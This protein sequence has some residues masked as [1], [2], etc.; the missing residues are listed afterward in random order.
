MALDTLS[1][2]SPLSP[3]LMKLYDQPHSMRDE[4]LWSL[5]TPL[6]PAIKRPAKRP[7]LLVSDGRFES[8]WA[9][10]A[11]CVREAELFVALMRRCDVVIGIKESGCDHHLWDRVMWRHVSY[12]IASV[13]ADPETIAGILLFLLPFFI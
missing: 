4:A 10:S 3:L 7:R 9:L 1:Y 12:M 6:V 11:P 8:D 2:S 13:D 5:L